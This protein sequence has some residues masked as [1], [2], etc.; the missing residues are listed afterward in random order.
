ML[1]LK[2]YYKICNTQFFYR[3]MDYGEK[4]I[5]MCTVMFFVFNNIFMSDMRYTSQKYFS[6]LFFVVYFVNTCHNNKLCIGTKKP[7]FEFVCMFVCMFN[8]FLRLFVY[9]VF[10][11][12]IDC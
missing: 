4:I 8:F 7:L 9:I 3:V 5:T 10:L 2:N 11:S 12:N 1:D 6:F